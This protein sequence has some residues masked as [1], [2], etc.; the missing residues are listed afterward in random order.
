MIGQEDRFRCGRIPGTLASVLERKRD[1]ELG[2]RIDF[3]GQAVCLVLRGINVGLLL[4][5]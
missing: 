1:G 2:V 5:S 4:S 3:P